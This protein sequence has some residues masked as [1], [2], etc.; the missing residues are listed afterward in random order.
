[1]AR[2]KEL[3]DKNRRLKKMVSA[4]FAA[5]CQHLRLLSRGD[6]G[7]VERQQIADIVT[8]GAA[9]QFG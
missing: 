8:D 9:W 7:V 2:M 1:M 5:P 4:N 3:E 6:G